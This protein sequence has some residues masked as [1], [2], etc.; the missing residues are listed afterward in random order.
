M[1]LWGVWLVSE[2]V[3]WRSDTGGDGG[4]ERINESLGKKGKKEDAA[5]PEIAKPCVNPLLAAAST[6]VRL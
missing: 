5:L 2:N 6:P 3:R 4:E 1:S